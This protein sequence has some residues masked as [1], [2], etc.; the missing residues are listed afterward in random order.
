MATV[1]G[2]DYIYNGGS[3]GSEPVVLPIIVA[4]NEQGQ[5]LDNLFQSTL[6]TSSI[7]Q[8]T[9]P[10]GTVVL[11][12]SNGETVKVF[13]DQNKG[14]VVKGIL[15]KND[16]AVIGTPTNKTVNV[17][18]GAG[19]N[20]VAVTANSKTTVGLGGGN[21]KITLA[22][23]GLGNTNVSLGTGKDTVVLSSE[24]LGNAV[25]K[26]FSA[27]DKLQILDRGKDGKVEAGKDYTYYKQGKDTVLVLMKDGKETNKITL[28][29]VK[30]S[31]VDV[32]DDGI[33]T[34]S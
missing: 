16:G 15:T 18:A 14:N 23:D 21:D 24:F 27:K 2:G 9:I 5:I 10:N 19:A 34:I 12:G 3:G 30:T 26:D 25:V 8:T 33:L 17:Q 1:P 22:T 31:K 11:K 20:Q 13:S 4:S 29:N 7:T 32:S 6:G 28:K